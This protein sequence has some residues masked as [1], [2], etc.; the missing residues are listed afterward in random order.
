MAD[1]WPPL[2]GSWRMKEPLPPCPRHERESSDSG[3]ESLMIFLPVNSINLRAVWKLSA[4]LMLRCSV[5][6]VSVANPQRSLH[7]HTIPKDKARA[8][9][10]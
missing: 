4:V 6:G 2:K 3:D 9:K 7:L 10:D 5:D 1:P 8:Q